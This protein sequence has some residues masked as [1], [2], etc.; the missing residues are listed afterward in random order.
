[1]TDMKYFRKTLTDGTVKEGLTQGDIRFDV[2]IK[3][4]GTPYNIHFGN[5]SRGTKPNNFDDLVG[6]LAGNPY[7]WDIFKK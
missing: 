2:S 1:M 7:F 3:P 6:S 4:D 5:N